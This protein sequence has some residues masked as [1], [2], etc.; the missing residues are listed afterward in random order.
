LLM[1]AGLGYT[2]SAVLFFVFPNFDLT[3]LGL[4]AFVGELLFYLWLLT[5]GV[6]APK[7]A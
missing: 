5:M 2:V 7:P 3:I 4:F 6:K 1:L